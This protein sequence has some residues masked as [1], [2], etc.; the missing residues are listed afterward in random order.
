MSK[1]T[2]LAALAL[3]LCASCALA[4]QAAQNPPKDYRLGPDSLPQEGVPKGRLEGPFLFKS[5]V[6]ANT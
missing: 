2:L 1:S 6:L 5:Q 4:Q 3:L